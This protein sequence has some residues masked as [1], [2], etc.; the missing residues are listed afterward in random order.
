MAAPATTVRAA[1]TGRYLDD[2]FSTKIAFA[3]DS[4]IELWEQTVTPPGIDGGDAI[5]IVTMHNVTWR[6]M[7]ARSLKTL[8]ESSFEALYDPVVYNSILNN[9]INQEGAITCH[10]PD[11]SKIDFYGFLQK[12]EPGELSEGEPPTATVTI[13][14]T[15]FDLTNNVEAG[16]VLTEVAGT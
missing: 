12:F 2:G 6:T 4:N 13:V 16:P 7:R 3:R 10:F 11:G 5:E 15:N 8:M 1:P 14:P 9:L